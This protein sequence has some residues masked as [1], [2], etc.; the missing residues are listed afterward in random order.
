MGLVVAKVA[1]RIEQRE[2][3]NHY[4]IT[5]IIHDTKPSS[6]TINIM[7]NIHKTTKPYLLVS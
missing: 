6:T 2:N 7:D 1:K 5:H 4:S 3:F